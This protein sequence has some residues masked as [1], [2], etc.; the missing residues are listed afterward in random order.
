MWIHLMKWKCIWKQIKFRIIC[1]NKYLQNEIKGV[2]KC[3]PHKEGYEGWFL[4]IFMLTPN[5][6]RNH[7]N[8]NK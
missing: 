5:N 1:L 2:M 7:F 4:N 6:K 8:Y 3:Y